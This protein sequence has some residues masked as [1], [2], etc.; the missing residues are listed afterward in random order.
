M[1]A[2]AAGLAVVTGIVSATEHPAPGI[3]TAIV[4]NHQGREVLHFGVKASGLKSAQKLAIRVTAV[5][6]IAKTASSGSTVFRTPLYVESLG[7]N[8]AGEINQQAEVLVPPAPANDLEV[9]AG[10]GTLPQCYRA[11]EPAAAAQ[12]PNCSRLHIVRP[13]EKPQLT[14]AWRNDRHSQAGLF[15]HVSAHDLGE[16]RIVLRIVDALSHHLIIATSWPP[17]ETG[18]ISK[19]ITAIVPAST[20]R[21]CV[22]ASTTQTTPSCFPPA[23]SGTAFVREV[24]PAP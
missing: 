7:P 23:G 18:L 9:Q 12:P 13:F 15:V 10:T 11:Y 17:T 3:T 6:F 5:T 1:L 16:H 20:Q 21:L 2:L 4:V 19:S 24:A 22:A 14:I 8:S